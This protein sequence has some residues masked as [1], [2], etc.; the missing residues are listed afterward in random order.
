MAKWVLFVKIVD[1]NQELK[2]LYQKQVDKH[3]DMIKN[4]EYNPLSHLL[5]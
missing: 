2:E 3:V 4:D 5:I 1:D